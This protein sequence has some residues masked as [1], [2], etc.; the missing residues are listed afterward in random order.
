MAKTDYLSIA[1]L[2]SSNNLKLS[3]GQFLDDFGHAMATIWD[4]VLIKLLTCGAH[5]ALNIVTPQ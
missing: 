2:A 5:A 3:I 4:L 1:R